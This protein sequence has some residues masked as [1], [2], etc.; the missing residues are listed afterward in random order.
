MLLKPRGLMVLF[1]QS[2]G[3]VPPFDLGMLSR[4][5]SLYVTRPTMGS[6]IASRAELQSRVNELFSL[7]SSGE[8]MLSIDRTMPLA[9]AAE[10]HL[11][12]EGRQTAGKI[13]LVP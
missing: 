3:V 1:G 6:Y 13:L 2:S 4:L 7:V 8:L 11:A 5:G 12:L 10:A 9:E